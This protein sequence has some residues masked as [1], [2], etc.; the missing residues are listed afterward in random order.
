MLEIVR[1]F[2]EIACFQK[3]PQ[4]VPFSRA[5]TKMLLLFYVVVKFLGL[6]MSSDY[7][8]AALQTGVDILLL[9]A[10]LHVALKWTRKSERFRQ[11]FCALLGTETLLAVFSIPAIAIMLVPT[12]GGFGVLGFYSMI[13]LILWHWAVI[14]HILS[15]ALE[16]AFSFSVG[17]ALLYMMANY[18]ISGFLV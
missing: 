15:H 8:T 18:F 10:F 12:A 13:A 3:A 16:Q 6:F 14:A 7:F 1:L 2:F 11:T 9:L 17:L 5:L 4:D